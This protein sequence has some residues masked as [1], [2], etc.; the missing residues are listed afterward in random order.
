MFHKAYRSDVRLV[1]PVFII[2]LICFLTWFFAMDRSTLVEFDIFAISP[3]I[4][5]VTDQLPD[6]DTITET[7][8][9]DLA[10]RQNLRWLV[11]RFEQNE[12][13]TT[14]PLPAL[15]LSGTYSA[16]VYLNGEFIGSKGV[17][18]LESVN[19]IAGPID[20]VIPLTSIKAGMNE[21]HILL[22]SHYVRDGQRSLLNDFR[23]LHSPRVNR[24]PAAYY[25]IAITSAGMLM[26]LLALFVS[27]GVRMRALGRH[28][29]A[30]ATALFLIL[31]LGAEVSRSWVNYP[32][33][34]HSLRMIVL[35]LCTVLAGISYTLLLLSQFANRFRI[36]I[37]TGLCLAIVAIRFLPVHLDTQSILSLGLCA[38]IG[39]CVLIRK[40]IHNDHFAQQILLMITT[41]GLFAIWQ[42]WLFLDNGMFAVGAVLLTPLAFEGY[43]NASQSIE[44]KPETRITIQTTGGVLSLNSSDVV[45][46]RS[47]GNYVLVLTRA[48]EEY[49]ARITLNDIS[50]QLP[51]EFRKTHRSCIINTKMAR[52]VIRRASGKYELLMDYGDPAPVSRTKASEL[53]HVIGNA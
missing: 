33:P 14:S 3:P 34:L 53:K 47:A 9:D 15:E 8:R 17:P 1:W 26:A 7:D 23:I 29:F 37:F 49:T 51:D 41:A 38:V 43:S 32:Y 48:N 22:S 13:H 27:L 18:A 5:E 44:S 36:Q 25:W 12:D 40:S 52:R 10:T 11:A 31:A 45:S 42:P 35:N 2:G 30:A 6:L 4:A 21:L 16:S 20:A 39:F 46:I 50:R 19:E 24:R 28:S